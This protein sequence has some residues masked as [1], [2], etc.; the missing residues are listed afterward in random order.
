[1]TD[2]VEFTAHFDDLVPPRPVEHFGSSDLSF[3]G[4]IEPPLKIHEDG[5]ERGCG[6][7]VWLAGEMLCNYLIE[8]SDSKGLLS[9]SQLSNGS[10]HFR[11]VLE[12]GSGT[13]L[14]GLCAGS[15]AKSNSLKVKVF[16]TDIGNLVELLN[17][18]TQLNNLDKYVFPEILMWGEA[19]AEKFEGDATD[20][21][22]LILAADCVYLEAAFT[23]LE[24]T[25]LDLTDGS[26]PPIVLMSYKKRRKAD[27]NFF[28][29]IRKSFQVI[30]VTD[31]AKSD[32]YV[33]HR[34]H[35]FQLIRISR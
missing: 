32:E 8:K 24:K 30:R 26:H 10:C 22:D 28:R 21:I 13:G 19:L 11:N 34:T 2:L 7:K 27:K 14:V 6:G 25:L 35:L 33:K 9:L 12:L 5:G 16:A 18:N 20:K 23:L 4:R 15:L 29:Q 3:G 31:F 17:V 1:M